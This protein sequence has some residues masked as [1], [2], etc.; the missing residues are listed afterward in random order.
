MPIVIYG[1]G[2]P[3]VAD[4]A[5]TCLRSKLHVAAW[6]RNIDGP[7]FAPPDARVIA[8]DEV[9]TTEL[10]YAFI[11]PQFTPGH[12][13][14]TRQHA[15]SLGFRRPAILVDPTAVVASSARIAAGSYVNSMA[16]IGAESIVGLFAFIN[17]GSSIGH[18]VALADFVSIG[19]AAVLAAGVRVGRGAVIGAGAVILPGIEIGENSVVGAGATVTRPV[20]PHSVVTGN[21][22][23]TV[24]SGIAGYRGFGV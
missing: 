19:P 9:S 4:V 14:A 3:I 17:R 1:I 7:V 10:D 13:L 21:P 23:R 2:S 20:S 8:A 24:E 15:Q 11:V 16:N 18:H 12:R 5:E 6:V 22:A